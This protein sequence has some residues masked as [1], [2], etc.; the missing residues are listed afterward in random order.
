MV[1]YTVTPAQHICC[2]HAAVRRNDV[3]IGEFTTFDDAVL[4]A[5]LLNKRVGNPEPGNQGEPVWSPCSCGHIAQDH[6]QEKKDDTFGCD[7][8]GCPDYDGDVVSATHLL[9]G[10]D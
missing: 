7:Y 6:N 5:E 8:C 3:V 10:G 2:Y 4:V 1:K 9:R